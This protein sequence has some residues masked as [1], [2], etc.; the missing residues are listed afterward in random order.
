MP[1]MFVMLSAVASNNPKRRNK[2][3]ASGAPFCFA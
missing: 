1:I 2:C 3:G